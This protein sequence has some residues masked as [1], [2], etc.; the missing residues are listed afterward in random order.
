MKWGPLFWKF[1]VNFL[2]KYLQNQEECSNAKMDIIVRT[3][4]YQEKFL[5]DIY[6][7]NL[8]RRQYSFKASSPTDLPVNSICFH[9]GR[10]KVKSYLS[11]AEIIRCLS[12]ISIEF[13]LIWESVHEIFIHEG[14]YWKY[15]VKKSPKWVAFN[16]SQRN[17]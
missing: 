16:N 13:E 5:C 17:C 1:E 10:F 6:C 9:K 7:L 14:D 15:S 12:Q 8:H 4:L 11:Y 3:E 2:R